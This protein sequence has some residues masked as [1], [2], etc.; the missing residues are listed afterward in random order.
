MELDSTDLVMEF[1]DAF[2]ITIPDADAEQLQTVGDVTQY[3]TARLAAERRPRDR[4]LVF[5][6]VCLVTCD[7][8]RVTLDELTEATS[9]GKDL[10]ID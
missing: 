9:F 1:E 6:M 5:A 2:E 4:D 7:Q 8:C 3:V 10:G